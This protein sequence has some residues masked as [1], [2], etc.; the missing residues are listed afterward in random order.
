MGRLSWILIL[1]CQ[2]LLIMNKLIGG[3]DW[4][5][6]LVLMPLWFYGASVVLF[7]LILIVMIV[8]RILK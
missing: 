1:L 4:S 7:S 5:W 2:A 6:G 3:L 8:R